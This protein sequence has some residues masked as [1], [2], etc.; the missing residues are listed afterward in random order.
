MS[1][2]EKPPRL[3]GPP[4]TARF[5]ERLMDA[6]SYDIS[7]RVQTEGHRRES[8]VPEVEEVEEGWYESSDGWRLSA[9]RVDHH[10]VDQ[11][12]G[13]R[14]EGDTGTLVISGDTCE[15]E[16][17]VHYA[18]GAD[19]LVH[20]VYSRRG[21]A[22]QTDLA[23]SPAARERLT[24]IA[25]YHTPSDRVGH[26]AARAGVKALVLTHLIFGIGGTPENIA[27]DAKLAYD[28]P[29]TVGNDLQSVS[30]PASNNVV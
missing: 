2:W 11:A 5:V 10:P 14:F 6:F 4:G 7:V 27:T 3:I 17:V 29:V 9:F 18:R 13:F 21:L 8:L 15:C 1:L 19:V 28:G 22:A 30:V 23:P 12:F 20:E 25:S 16:N 26:V 24:R